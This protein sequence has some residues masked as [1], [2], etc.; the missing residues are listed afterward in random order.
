M[1]ETSQ[2]GRLSSAASKAGAP[3]SSERLLIVAGSLVGALVLLAMIGLLYL[4]VLQI[5]AACT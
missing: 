5:Q 3:L 1:Y 4:H 2:A